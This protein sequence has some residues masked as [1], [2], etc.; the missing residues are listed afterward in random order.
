MI[1]FPQDMTVTQR[2]ARLME[3]LI[4][5]RAEM[6]IREV[7]A[8]LGLGRTGVYSLLERVSAISPNV[9]IEDGVVFYRNFAEQE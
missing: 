9:M 1:E 2:T 7:A 5:E 8:R 6:P 3:W 4:A